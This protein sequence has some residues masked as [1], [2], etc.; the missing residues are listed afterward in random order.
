[1]PW[2]PGS[3]DC[4]RHPTYRLSAFSTDRLY[5]SAIVRDRLSC[6]ALLD[7]T[8]RD[9]TLLGLGSPPSSPCPSPTVT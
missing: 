3:R 1:M 7:P 2:P 6:I 5:L 4:T 9:P 8:S